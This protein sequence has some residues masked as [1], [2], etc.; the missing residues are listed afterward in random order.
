[1]ND[2]TADPGPPLGGLRVLDLTRALS[3]PLCTLVLAGLGAN[4]IKI[5]DPDGGDVSRGNAPYLGPDGLSMTATGPDDLSLAL[6][7]RCKGK[8]SVT[9]N[10]KSPA[11]VQV[12]KDLVREVDVVVENFSAGTAERLGVGYEAARAANPT[13]IYCSI[14]G[15]GQDGESGVR[16]M[17]ALVQALSGLMLASGGPDDPP[18]RVGVPVADVMTP[19][20]AVIGILSALHRRETTGLGEHIDVSML[21]A[22]TSLVAVEDW[23]AL[24]KLG[25][26]L[27]TGPTLPRLA[28]FGLYRCADGWFA[29]VAPQD[30]MVRSVFTAMGRDDLGK[31]PRFATR[32]AR[33][34]NEVALREEIEDWSG[35][36]PV[37][38]VVEVLV[39]A[40][41]SAAPVRTPIE[42]VFDERVVA[43]NET[44]PVMHPSLGEVGELRTMGLPIRFSSAPDS[45]LDCAPRLG[46]DTD[47]V[48][49]GLAGYSAERL[50]EL[51][52]AGAI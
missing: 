7:N 48:L 32:D 22:L 42:A 37:A 17:D 24:E 27:R 34:G 18:I 28:P 36:Y 4:V 15:F 3:G 12:F 13:I 21:G 30:R 39:A 50:E 23:Q 38:H 2:E 26:P 25:Q 43:R 20:Y 1:L 44:R 49:T 41:V 16:A 31:D 29:L 52:D 10:L 6:L 51:R 35:Q 9:V 5:E 46:Q 47:S 14:S 8:R 40:G 11:G 33:V 19:L 45:R